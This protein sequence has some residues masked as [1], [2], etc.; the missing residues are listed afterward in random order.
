MSSRIFAC[1]LLVIAVNNLNAK[2]YPDDYN[3]IYLDI[4]DV[5]SLE[6][7][8]VRERTGFCIYLLEMEVN[9]GGFHQFILNSSGQF[10]LQTV[11]ALQK[12]GADKT[13]SLLGKAI[14]IACPGGYPRDSS[15]HQSLLMDF[16]TVSDELYE[17]DKEFYKYEDDLALLINEYL[18]K[19]T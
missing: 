16:D 9:N 11:D 18:H 14:S 3:E 4:N 5:Q 10:A 12:I 2:N 6:G 19:G 13:A 7:L 8:S 1:V 17:L 15:L